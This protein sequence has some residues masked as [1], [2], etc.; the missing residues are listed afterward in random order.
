LTTLQWLYYNFFLV[1]NDNDY[2]GWVLSS[3]VEVRGPAR[4]YDWDS[5]LIGVRMTKTN[6]LSFETCI[7]ISLGFV[8]PTVIKSYQS[9]KRREMWAYLI[10]ESNICHS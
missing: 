7:F 2:W 5:D 6:G 10:P 9:W 1:A 4:S 8:E 3:I